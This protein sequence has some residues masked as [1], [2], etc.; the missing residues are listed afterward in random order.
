MDD[1]H[2]LLQER[3]FFL[4]DDFGHLE[5]LDASKIGRL[6]PNAVQGYSKAY[7]CHLFDNNEMLGSVLTTLFNVQIYEDFIEV[8]N[9]PFFREHSVQMT[10][11]FLRSV[12]RQVSETS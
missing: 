3:E 7:I 1:K 11:F 2:E 10:D 8:I 4:E 6:T 12:C 5:G 9:S